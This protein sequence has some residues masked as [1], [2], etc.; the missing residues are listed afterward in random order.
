MS[1]RILLPLLFTLGPLYSQPARDQARQLDL[2]FIGAQL[3]KLQYDFFLNVTPGNFNAAVA[4]LQARIPTL[5]DA[6]FYVGL[7]RLAAMAGDDHTYVRLDDTAAVAA[8]F[9][10]FPLRFRWLDD[11]VFVVAAS[12]KYSQSLGA[13]LVA[14]GNTS[15]DGVMAA[16]GTIYPH[17]N[18][19]RI[20]FIASAIRFQQILQGLDLVPATP[21]TPL[22]FQTLAGDQF[23]LDVGTENDAL[24]PAPDPG[25]G[26]MPEYLQNSGQNYWFTY[27]PQRKLLYLKY[28]KCS[29]D[30][31]DPI[32]S[33]TTRFLQAVDANPFDTLVLDFRGNNGG[34]PTVINPLLDGLIERIPAF[35][36]NTNLQIYGVI[37]D[38]TFSAASDDAESLK[39]PPSQYGLPVPAGFDPGRL[40]HIIGEP[41]SEAPAHAMRTSP[42]TLPSSKL[43]GEY[44]TIFQ[45]A[46]SFIS[47]DYDAGGPSFGPDIRVSLRSTDYFARHDPVLAALLARFQ[48]AP[49]APSGAAIAV[50]GATFRADQGLAPGSLASVFGSFPPGVNGVQ[51]NGQAAQVSAAATSQ[52]NFIVPAAANLGVANISV[53]SGSSVVAQGQATLTPTSPGIFAVQPADPA[54]PGSVLN[55]DST[56]NGSN[57]PA[58]PGSVLQIFA[59]GYGTLDPSGQAPVQVFLGEMPAPVMFSGPAPQLPGLWQINAQVPGGLSG[60]VPLYL[61]AGN[62]ASNGVTVWVH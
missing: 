31:A 13:R 55:Q 29:D 34:D 33:F 5:T 26:S 56:L 17:Y 15:I 53:L 2:D 32:A 8:G 46:P 25:Q 12:A 35:L 60:Q 62:I 52:V 7:A 36:Q 1:S 59:T 57:S 19:Q 47:P 45:A 16:L 24:I 6:E 27:S 18:N 23:T 61:V 42:F 44:T 28:N 50:N 30:P 39:T 11:G 10:Q 43:D 9:Q 20:H 21:T 3:P 58:A 22:T 37:D 51:V 48:G 49:A 40:I 14:A 38:G 54:Q 41:T 4:A